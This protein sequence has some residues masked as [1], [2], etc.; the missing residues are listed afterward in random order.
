MQTP[1]NAETIILVGPPVIRLFWN[2]YFLYL[3]FDAAPDDHKA[4]TGSTI[5]SH[6]YPITPNIAFPL[7]Q[8]YRLTSP[9]MRYVTTEIISA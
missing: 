1:G 6:K 4:P 7:T 8:S 9:C 3:G 2:C 5:I